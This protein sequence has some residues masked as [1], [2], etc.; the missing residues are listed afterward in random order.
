MEYSIEENYFILRS[1]KYS[2]HVSLWSGKAYRHFPEV[3]SIP[4]GLRTILLEEVLNRILPYLPKYSGITVLQRIELR[5]KVEE[6][7]SEE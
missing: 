7:I 5:R 2:I 6:V 4:D 3:T 1:G